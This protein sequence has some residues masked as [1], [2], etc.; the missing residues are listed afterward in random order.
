MLLQPRDDGT[1]TGGT[2]CPGGVVLDRMRPF[3]KLGI[4]NCRPRRALAVQNHRQK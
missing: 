1:E 4:V 3:K 2:T